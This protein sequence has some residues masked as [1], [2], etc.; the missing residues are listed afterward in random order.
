MSCLNAFIFIHN[1]LCFHAVDD[2]DHHNLNDNNQ[3][4]SFAIGVSNDFH[5]E[6]CEGFGS[7]SRVGV[8]VDLLIAVAKDLEY[9]D[10]NQE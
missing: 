10:D 3:Y 1:L 5:Y 8:V 7:T 2:D 4:G 9:K 6:S